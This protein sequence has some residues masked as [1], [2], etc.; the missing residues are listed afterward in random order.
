MSAPLPV[1]LLAENADDEKSPLYVIHTRAPRFIAE[2]RT[3]GTGERAEQV[4]DVTWQDAAPDLKS[5]AIH[6]LMR[7]ASAYLRRALDE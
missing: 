2:L 5:P 1:F 4:L 6:L 7:Q 3:E